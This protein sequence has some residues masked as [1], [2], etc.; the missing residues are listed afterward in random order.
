MHL[1]LDL[2]IEA[3][4]IS[5]YVSLGGSEPHEFTGYASLIATLQSLRA[6]AAEDMSVPITDGAS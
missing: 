3:E 6:V 5:G 2:D 1:H 4:P